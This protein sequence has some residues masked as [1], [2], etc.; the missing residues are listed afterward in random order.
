M[1]HSG[2]EQSASSH[3]QVIPQERCE[4]L[5]AEHSTGRVAWQAADGPQLLPITYAWYT[6][7]VVFRTSPYGVMSQLAQ[8]TNVAFEIDQVDE[9][10]GSGWNVLVRGTAEGITEP[11]HLVQL[12]SREGLV[13]WATG[14]RN[15]FIAITP[16]SI[17]GR[18][19]KAPFAD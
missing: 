16:H 1:S 6:E 2:R 13:P 8:R 4:H 7:R 5:L 14:V 10:A 15:L 11:Y 12:W 17:S 9:K 3:F 18:S 19:V